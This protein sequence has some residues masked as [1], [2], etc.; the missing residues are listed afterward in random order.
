MVT[1]NKVGNVEIRI[2]VN[3]FVIIRI[4]KFVGIVTSPFLKIVE[5]ENQKR[6][7]IKSDENPEG[8]S[9]Q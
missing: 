8:G 1:I 4:K 9:A 2:K 3:A 6:T 7:N 5:F